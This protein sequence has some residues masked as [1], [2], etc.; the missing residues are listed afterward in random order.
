MNEFATRA[1]SVTSL[2]IELHDILNWRTTF[3]TETNYH[4]NN[5]G[6]SIEPSNAHNATIP[7][8]QSAIKGIESSGQ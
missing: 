4:R 7:P 6:P 3:A 8:Y 2:S 5:R 1:G